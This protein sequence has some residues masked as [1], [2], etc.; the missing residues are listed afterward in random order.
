[1]PQVSGTVEAISTKWDKFSVKL[2]NGNWYGTKEEFYKAD[3]AKN[4]GTGINVGDSLSFNSGATGKYMSGWSVTGKGDATA[5]PSDTGPG[6]RTSGGFSQV[7]VAVGA[8][9]N[10]ATQ[11][12]GAADGGEVNLGF[13]ED[14]AMNMYELAERLKEQASAGD[15]RQNKEQREAGE[16]ALKALEADFAD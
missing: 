10:Q 15:I 6:K 7:G 9:M 12:H 2:D 16:Q 1:M 4:G 8:A 5:R 13:I 11:L 3:V 14:T